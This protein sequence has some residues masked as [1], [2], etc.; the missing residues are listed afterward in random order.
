[1]CFSFEMDLN[2]L[3]LLTM[4][5]LLLL[6]SIMDQRSTCLV[7]FIWPVH[8]LRFGGLIPF[9]TK[10]CT[11]ASVLSF[12]SPSVPYRRNSKASEP[13]LGTPWKTSVLTSLRTLVMNSMDQLDNKEQLSF[14]LRFISPLARCMHKERSPN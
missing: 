13:Y 4:L 10:P 9:Q 1:M 12:L 11:P 6:L 2:M 8:S 14:P 3:M 7:C 5:L